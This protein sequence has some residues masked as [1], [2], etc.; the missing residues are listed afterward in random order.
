MLEMER[1]MAR[2]KRAEWWLKQKNFV[3]NLLLSAQSWRNGAISPLLFC[4]LCV[5]MYFY[6]N[7]TSVS[8]TFLT[9]Y[10]L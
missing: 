5:M 6:Q 3:F 2:C 7:V 8:C 10:R 1:N 9:F 4:A